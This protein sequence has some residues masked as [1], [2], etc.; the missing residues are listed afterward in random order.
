MNLDQWHKT[1]LEAFRTQGHP[2]SNDEQRLLLEVYI[3]ENS[4]K[5]ELSRR[6]MVTMMHEIFIRANK[7]KT[8][9]DPKR[10]ETDIIYSSVEAAY[11]GASL[12][13][14]NLTRSFLTL[15]KEYIDIALFDPQSLI[16]VSLLR[17]IN[18]YKEVFFPGASVLHAA[19][20]AVFHARQRDTLVAFGKGID[21]EEFF[22]N[23]PVLAHTINPLKGSGCLLVILIGAFPALLA[24]GIAAFL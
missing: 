23:N 19:P 9:G 17:L 6:V 4:L 21:V 1:I 7:A 12:T 3:P 10:L 22:R 24:A 18:F 13:F 15:W 8:F 14:L 20:Y 5:K 11:P 2:L 16:Q